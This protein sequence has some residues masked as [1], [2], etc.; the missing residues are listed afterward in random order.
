MAAPEKILCIDRNALPSSWVNSRT[1]LPMGLST[2]ITQCTRSG[3]KFVERPTAEEDTQKK[4]V[5]PYILLQTT[6]G[7]KTAVYNRQGSEKRLHDLW[8]IGIGGHINPIDG[9]EQAD[10]KNILQAGMN[11]ELDEELVQ[12]PRSDQAHFS[13]I[14]SEDIT[15]VGRVH[16]GAIFRI[17][18]NT[19]AA[20]VAGPELHRFHWIETEK[21]ETLNLELWFQLALE[22]IMSG[23][24]STP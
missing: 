11:R 9:N 5:I 20:Y 19:P 23:T 13:G 3:F 7:T 10:F 4:Q 6:D 17:T 16:L 15:P 22:L 18:T 8:S 14:I 12:R 1:V 24:G 21:L 2:F